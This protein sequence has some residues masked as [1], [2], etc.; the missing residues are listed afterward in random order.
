VSDIAALVA[1]NLDVWTGAIE[2]KSGA[3]RGGGK[4]I[5]PYGID[6]LRALILDLAVRGKLLPQHAGDE[7]A[8]E[9][10]KRI[11][12]EKSR[13]IA[14]GTAKA[15]KPLAAPLEWPFAIPAGWAWSQLGYVTNYGQTDKADPGSVAPDTWVLELEDVEKG[16]SRLIERVRCAD[17]PFQSQKN[18]FQIGDVIYGKLRPYLDKVII[19]DEE[20]VCTTEMVPMRGYAGLK[21]DYIRLFLKTPFFIL[22]ATN[23]AHGMNLPRLA[24][25]KAREAPFALPPIA[26][27]QRI[28]AKVD[29]LMALCDALEQ[30]SAGAMAAH[31]SLVEILLATLVNS[32]DAMNLA[33]D[34]ARLESHFD[35][36]F[37]TDA[38]IDTLKQ[39]ILA[40]AVR[41]KLVKQSDQDEAAS[42]L[43]ERTVR[44]KADLIRQGLAKR[45][46]ALPRLTSINPPFELPSGWAWARFPELGILERGKSRHRPRNDPKLFSPGAYPLIQTGEVARATGLINETHSH[47]SELGLSQSKLWEKGT[48]CITIAANIAD[49]AIMGFDACFP[50]SV[51]GFVPS[52][53]MNDTRYFLY[54][55][56]TAKADLLRFAPSTAQKNINLGILETLLIPL[57]PLREMDEIVA[58]VEALMALCDALKARLADAAQTQR[59]LAAAITQRAAA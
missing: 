27:Q 44:G 59:H 54:F 45:D 16:T 55:I 58:K 50:D 21:S 1:D 24:T 7:P 6:R 39:T 9:L 43:L 38:S 26:E 18:A 41:G 12:A 14:S 40:L 29:E 52:K 57:P 23:A 56:R 42:E 25:E 19:A 20:G 33:R 28:V 46:K 47:Y 13:L 2:R 34:W 36:L 22:L 11:K 32:A 37:T 51:V 5:S 8:T 30:E 35:T 4:R 10:L 48:L 53:P 17:K 3:G 31:Q 49:A 15:G